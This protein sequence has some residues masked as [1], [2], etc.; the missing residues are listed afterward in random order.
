MELGIGD[1]KAFCSMCA[2]DQA[3]VFVQEILKKSS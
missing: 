1:P 3:L 2:W